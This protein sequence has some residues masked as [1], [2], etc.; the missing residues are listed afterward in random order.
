MKESMY[1][2]L[3]RKE[4]PSQPGFY[5]KSVYWAQGF[6]RRVVSIAAVCLTGKGLAH[7]GPSGCDVHTS[8]RASHNPNRLEITRKW[9]QR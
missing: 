5:G 7:L 9:Q 1:A 8:E 4:S 3:R 2:Q 6:L